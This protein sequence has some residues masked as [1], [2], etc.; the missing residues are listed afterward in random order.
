MAWPRTCP[1][2]RR[3][4]KEINTIS[5]F[6]YFILLPTKHSW[7][8]LF[9]LNRCHVGLL[10]V[11][12]VPLEVVHGVG[13]ARLEHVHIVIVVVEIVDTIVVI[14]I[15]LSIVRDTSAIHR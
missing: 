8:N 3:K 1:L 14:T 10:L 12:P 7:P 15:V 13:V 4:K 11:P 5:C 2:K 9:T 6:K